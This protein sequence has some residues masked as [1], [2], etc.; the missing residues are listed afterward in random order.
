[1]MNSIWCFMILFG[2]IVGSFNGKIAVLSD[3]ILSSS[4]EAV[5]LCILMF[6]IVGLWS[7]LMSIALSLGITTKLQQMLSPFLSFLFPNLKNK[8]AK[9]YISTNIIANML[10]LGWAATPSGLKAMEEL[11]KN[12]IPQKGKII[13]SHISTNEMCTFLVLNISSLQLI[14]VSMIAY[15]SQYNSHNPGA[16]VAPAIIATTISTLAGVS[17]CKIMCRRVRK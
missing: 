14:P 11:A 9:E 13:E 6:G 3:T 4:K 8:K 2:L 5:E 10:G 1:M 7:G 16:I 12:P 17:F 15:R